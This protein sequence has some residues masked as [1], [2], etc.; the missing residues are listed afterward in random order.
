MDS[1]VVYVS[2]DQRCLLQA[3][4]SGQAVHH[5]NNG[6]R[7]HLASTSIPNDDY[8]ER[9]RLA[10][11]LRETD[12]V[13]AQAVSLLSTVHLLLPR[14]CSGSLQL[15]FFLFPRPLRPLRPLLFFLFPRPLLCLGIHPQPVTRARSQRESEGVRRVYPV[16]SSGESGSSSSSTILFVTRI[17]KG[18]ATAF[19][20]H[21]TVRCGSHS[22]TATTGAS[23]IVSSSCSSSSAGCEQNSEHV[24]PDARV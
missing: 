3:I 21:V 8:F 16:V 4:R 22:A 13:R 14:L 19:F 7:D 17:N 15:S 2:P 18:R 6:G 1:L 11:A 23:S 5:I 9:P 12:D 10:G 20:H 24:T